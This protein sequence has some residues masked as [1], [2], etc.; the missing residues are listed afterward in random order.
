MGLGIATGFV[1]GSGYT[2]LNIVYV[3]FNMKTGTKHLFY[4]WK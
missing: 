3:R 1:V 4:L 2:I